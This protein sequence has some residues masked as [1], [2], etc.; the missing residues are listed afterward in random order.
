MMR[1][2]TRPPSLI[3]SMRTTT[4]SPCIASLRCGAGDV[5]VAAGFERPLGRDEAVAGRVRLQPA[6]VEIHL[7]GQAEALPADLDEIAR[8]D[9]RL[10]VPLERGALVARNLQ[11]LEEFAHAGGMVHPLAHERENLVARKHVR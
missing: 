8:G 11:E 9:E 4:R 3:R 10:E 7:L 1:P 5:D 2:S 6:D